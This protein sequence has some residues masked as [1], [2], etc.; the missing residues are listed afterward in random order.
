[1]PMFMVLVAMVIFAVMMMV[2]EIRL[3]AV[4][5]NGI[6]N[7]LSDL[8]LFIPMCMMVVGYD[9]FNAQNQRKTENN[10]QKR[11]GKMVGVAKL[12]ENRLKLIFLQ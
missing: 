2:M 9:F 11:E 10:S 3:V 5:I 7:G 1:M 12:I 6:E 4:S 8:P